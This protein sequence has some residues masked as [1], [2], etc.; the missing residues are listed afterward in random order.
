MWLTSTLGQK[1]VPTS[2]EQQTRRHWNPERATSGGTT[3]TAELLSKSVIDAVSTNTEFI[4][5]E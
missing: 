3:T 4:L 2:L 5:D 1:S